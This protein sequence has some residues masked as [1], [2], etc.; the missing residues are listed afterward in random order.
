MRVLVTGGTGLVGH[1]LLP[2]L[3]ERG[4]QVL[5]LSRREHPE[6]PAGCTPL[7]GDPAVSGPWLDE[8]TRCDAVVHLAGENVFARRWRKRFRRQLYDSRIDSTK[9]IA[10]ELAK[11]PRRTDG[12]TKALVSASAVGY[13][14][15]RGREELDETSPPGDDFLA[16]VCI[17][18][19]AATRAA[20][21][22]GVRVC[23]VRVGM[24]LDGEG[25]ALRKLVRPFRWFLGGPV[26]SGQQW[27]SWIHVQ[28][29]VGL[30]LKALDDP[31]AAGPINGTAPEPITN[32]GFCQ[33][34]GKVLRRPCWLP[35]PGFAIRILLGQVASVVTSGQRVLPAKA[36][37]TGYE[38]RFPD[39]EPAL[40]DLLNRPA[41]GPAAA[42]K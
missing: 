13:Y 37:R 16:R 38:F 21:E 36:A 11:C 32:W 25:G 22:A 34:L 6:F 15:P 4:D 3:L 29:L 30:I 8:L 20:A 41:G 18:W 24:V 26:A 10:A 14:G 12:S 35:V 40:R 5:A 1:R 42:E 17:D 2:R 7:Q 27:I 9:L 28:D 33:T 19:E 23:N 31:N 39:L